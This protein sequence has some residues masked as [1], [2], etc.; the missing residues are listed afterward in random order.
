MVEKLDL[1]QM[2]IDEKEKKMNKKI[3]KYIVT[4][5]S[6]GVI[7]STCTTPVFANKVSFNGKKLPKQPNGVGTK[8]VTLAKA[9]AN[10]KQPA[11]HQQI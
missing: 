2:L 1:K 3:K 4:I 9:N 7:F 10:E 5:F 11:D 8:M 6:L